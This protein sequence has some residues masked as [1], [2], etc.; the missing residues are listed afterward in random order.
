MQSSPNNVSFHPAALEVLSGARGRR[1]AVFP[2]TEYEGLYRNGGIGT[3]YRELSEVFRA[4]GWFTILF[5]LGRKPDGA[6][7]AFPGLD[8]LFHADECE[9]FLR[10]GPAP[11]AMAGSHA[12]DFSLNEAIRSLLFLEALTGAFPGQ[13]I[14]VE[15]PEM[16][17]FAYESLKAKESGWLDSSVR[18]GVTMHSGNEFIHE[19]NGS[20]LSL[21]HQFLSQVASREEEAF[22]CA[23]LALYPSESLHS[24]VKSYGWRTDHAVRLPYFVPVHTDSEPPPA[25]EEEGTLEIIFFGRLEERK[26][27]L[28]FLDALELLPDSRAPRISVTFLGKDVRLYSAATGRVM[29]REFIE[30]RMKRIAL[31]FRLV[32]ELGSAEAI[33]FVR[34]RLRTCVVC[35]ASAT[36]NF[37]NAALEMGQLPVPL[38]VCDTPGFHDTLGLIGRTEGLHWVEPQ[39]ARSLATQLGKALAMAGSSPEAPRREEVEAINRNLSAKRFALVDGTLARPEPVEEPV[40]AGTDAWVLC[41]NDLDATLDTLDSLARSQQALE[42]IFL[43]SPA[44]WTDGEEEHLRGR[45]PQARIT[46]TLPE[47]GRSSHILLVRSGAILP[48]EAPSDF[49]RAAH[50]SAA[51]MVTSAEWDASGERVRMFPPPAVARIL[52]G[53]E[54]AGSVVLVSSGFVASLPPLRSRETAGVMHKLALGAAATGAKIAFIPYPCC[55][56][57]SR[58]TAGQRRLTDPV[59][60]SRYAASIPAA[61]WQNRELFGLALGVQQLDEH[62]IATAGQLG[63]RAREIEH[64]RAE[65]QAAQA[66]ASDRGEELA[67]LQRSK[68]WRA[69][70]PLRVLYKIGSAFARRR[71]DAPAT[72]REHI[73]PAPALHAGGPD[74]FPAADMF[75]S[76]ATELGPWTKIL[77][78][79]VLNAGAGSRDLSP[80]I[81]GELTNQDIPEGLHNQNIHIQ[82][83]LHCIPRVDG[84]FD[85]VFCN[86]V[87]E[88]V[89]NPE[90]VMAEF[91]RVCRPGGHLYLCVPFLQPE[92]KDP[93]DYQ[94]YTADGLAALVERH[95]FSVLAVEPMHSIYTT[96][97]WIV[98]KCF[99]AGRACATRRCGK[100][101][102]PSCATSAAAAPNR[103]LPPL[104]PTGSSLFEGKMNPPTVRNRPCG[105]TWLSSWPC[106]RWRLP[107]PA[108]YRRRRRSAAR[109]WDWTRSAISNSSLASSAPPA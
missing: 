100:S 77:K 46:Q 65:L 34:A 37:P 83:P 89:A 7:A 55:T 8:A 40:P 18:I 92:H 26:G 105:P 81:E 97:S 36:D 102:I 39:S 16:C 9:D 109:A 29:S 69:T 2:T 35:L 30:G 20:L 52:R 104:R 28:D 12:N 62:G 59:A 82:S 44:G 61:R 85:V 42:Q 90:E 25:E 27:L 3:Y 79:R 95:G 72:S 63:E 51:A 41:D 6:P 5:H 58:E 93:T 88:H 86:A 4:G 1:I 80:Y 21:D 94:R 47:L 84:H 78:G 19:A 24:I 108:R 23:D 60:L 56:V 31:P 101:C 96:L 50:R 38:V 11:R 43:W 17:G 13:G 70:A 76:L 74:A 75:P 14:Y 71:V 49:L 53:A 107:T 45:H 10:M 103:C 54:C 87:L 15:F 32:T 106:A 73:G 68:S 48:P 67:A 64:L 99:R 66:A 57:P 98:V 91:R 22:R 33:S